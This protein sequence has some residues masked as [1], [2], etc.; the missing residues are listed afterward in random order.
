MS[1]LGRYPIASARGYKYVMSA[2]DYD[3]VYINAIPMKSRKSN[4]LVRAFELGYKELTNAELTA[5]LIR[6]DNKISNNLITAM[7]GQDLKY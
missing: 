3:S 4:K 1:Q 5:Q 2:Y 7:K 6:L